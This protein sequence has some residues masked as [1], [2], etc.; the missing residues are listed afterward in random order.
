MGVWVCGREE[1]VRARTRER[2]TAR[3][4]THM[5]M[6]DKVV[7]HTHIFFCTCGPKTC[8]LIGNELS[9]RPSSRPPSRPCSSDN[10]ALYG[11]NS[12]GLH[13]HQDNKAR[14]LAAL[15]EQEELERSIASAQVEM[16][17]LIKLQQEATKQL[18]NTRPLPTQIEHGT[19]GMLSRCDSQDDLDQRGLESIAAAAFAAVTQVC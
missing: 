12:S 2:A 8:V 18:Q 5:H 13:I 3:T 9:G 14:S 6:K 17:D 15:Q 7:L 19:T 1:H 4:Y 11:G 16:D 10:E